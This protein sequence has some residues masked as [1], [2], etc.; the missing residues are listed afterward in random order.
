MARE[1][2]HSPLL[3]SG[4][5]GPEIKPPR[6]HAVGPVTSYSATAW[7]AARQASLSFSVSWS[8]LK[9]VYRVGD[10]IQPSHP[11]SSPIA[12]NLSQHQGPLLYQ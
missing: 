2:A 7:T 3:T 5:S 6:A 12:L 1:G 9:L 4:G 11:L 8:S 10:A